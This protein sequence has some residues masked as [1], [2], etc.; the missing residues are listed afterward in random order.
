M[1]FPFRLAV[2]KAL[3]TVCSEFSHLAYEAHHFNVLPTLRSHLPGGSA[4]YKLED[5]NSEEYKEPHRVF[6]T[7]MSSA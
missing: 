2:F 7:Y 5:G 4:D 3:L 6:K 1:P